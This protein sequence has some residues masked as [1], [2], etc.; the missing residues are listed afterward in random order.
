MNQVV[1]T[2]DNLQCEDVELSFFAPE[3]ELP[4]VIT[5]KQAGLNISQWGEEN[6]GFVEQLLA[7]YGGILF[8]EFD[9]GQGD[10]F[11][12]FIA[13]VSSSALSY[14]ERSSPRSVF[15]GNI[16]TSTDHPQDKEIFL[17]SEQSYNVRFP[18]RI[19]FYCQTPASSGG[20]TPIADARKIYQR[21]DPAIRERFEQGQYRYSRYFWPMMGLTWQTAFQTEDKKAVEQYCDNNQIHYQWDDNGALQ[22]YQIRPAVAKHPVTG[23]KCW[24]NH[25]TFFHIST[26]DADTQEILTC[27]FSENELPNNTY[28]GDGSSIEPTVM[29]SLRAAYEEEKVT[30]DWQSGDVLMLDNMM[31]THGRAAFAGQRKILVGMSELSS[32]AEQ[33][34]L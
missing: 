34:E 17:H 29:D 22:T 26:L 2:I 20:A 9:S 13:N 23:E 21:I 33:E 12:S 32:W 4:L 28:Y 24:F 27:S 5:P 16:Y 1:T 31:T 6:K 14:S 8:R 11:E 19:F 10:D 30:F 15:N 7:R 25:C 3:Q 18:M